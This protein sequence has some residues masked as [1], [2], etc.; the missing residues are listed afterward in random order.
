MRLPRRS[1]WRRTPATRRSSRTGRARRRTRRLATS[2]SPRTRARSRPGR[3]RVRSESRSTTSS[4]GSKQSSA[5]VPSGPAGPP[6]HAPVAEME[7][8]R[9]RT[10][11][12]ATIG[13]SSS[14]HEMVRLLAEA[15]MDAV[16]LNLSHGTQ[17]EHAQTAGFTRAV[18][19]ELGRPLALIADLQGPKL[20]VGDL[21]EPR[22]LSTGDEVV[23]AGDDV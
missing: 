10:K 23:I 18:Q 20:R 1:G 15:G 16:R 2:P 19:A 22:T 8:E 21:D 12:V 6:T 17:D 7:A 5:R 9:R 14:S 4:C 3:P 11:I 13:P